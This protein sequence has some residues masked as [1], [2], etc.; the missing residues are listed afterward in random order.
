[1][2]CATSPGAY[3]FISFSTLETS[4]NRQLAFLFLSD[5]MKLIRIKCFCIIFSRHNR[6]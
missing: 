3:I 6:G 5:V 2:I 4:I 1:M